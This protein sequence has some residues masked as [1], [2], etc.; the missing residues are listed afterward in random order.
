MVAR[1]DGLTIRMGN[2]MNISK[3]G[4]LKTIVKKTMAGYA[5]VI[6]EVY[7]GQNWPIHGAVELPDGNFEPHCW[8]AFGEVMSKIPD[9]RLN[10]DVS[11]V[12]RKPKRH[13]TV[14]GPGNAIYKKYGGE[15]HADN[16][17]AVYIPG[18]CEMWY[19]HGKLHNLKGPAVISVTGEYQW[20]I[21][22][23]RVSEE[24]FNI[25]AGKRNA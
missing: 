10:L 14:E 4:F 16:G 25:I 12:E 22:G 19:R 24:Q 20:F 23:C 1:S 5:V 2:N 6:Y 7:P 15:L 17:P 11:G 3:V 9:S 13:V 21:D 18:D 8:T